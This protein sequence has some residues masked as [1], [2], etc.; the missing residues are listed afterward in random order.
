LLLDEP[1]ASLDA[2]SEDLVMTALNNAARSQ[3]TLLVTHQLTEI[4][5]Y[6]TI[7]VMDGGRLVQQGDYQTLRA[8]AGPFATLLAQ[9]Q[10]AL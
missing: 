1:S 3:T 9:R 7:W 8:E 5:E 4:A 2:H 6:D 10:E